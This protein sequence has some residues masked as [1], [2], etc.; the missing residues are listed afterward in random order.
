[1]VT[2]A[3]QAAQGTRYTCM[4]KHTPH[5]YTYVHKN[6]LVKGIEKE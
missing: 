4:H 5:T 2:E 3:A 6:A 1:M